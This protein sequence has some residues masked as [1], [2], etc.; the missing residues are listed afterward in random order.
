MTDQDIEARR[1][2]DLE[3]YYRQTAERRARGLCIT[4]AHR[5]QTAAC[6]A[7]RCRH[8]DWN[9]GRQAGAVPQ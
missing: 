3:R 2:R 8:H 9:L 1:K 5:R 4:A 7:T 6:A